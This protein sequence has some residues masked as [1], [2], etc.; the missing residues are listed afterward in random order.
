[1]TDPVE[2]SL[3]CLARHPDGSVEELPKERIDEI[4]KLTD[5]DGTLV[6]VSATAP[7]D[8][9]IAA[10]GREFRL[11]PLAL[12]DLHKQQQRPKLD[13]YERAAHGRRLRGGE[14]RARRA[15]SEIHMFVGAGWLLSVT[16]TATPMLDAVRDGFA[17]RRNGGPDTTGT[18]LYALLDAAV[19][20][21]FP[22]LDTISERI[23]ALEDRVLEG[24]ADRDSLAE[25]LHLKRRLLELRR[26]LAPMRDVANA[27]LRRDLEIVDASSAPYYQDLYDHLVRV[28]DQV[29]I[30]RDLLAAVLDARLTVASNSLNAIMKRLTAFTVVLM[31]PTLIA[32]IYGM[33]FDLM[34]EL[35]WPFGYP[36]AL[37]IMAPRWSSPS[38]TSAARAGSRAARGLH[39]SDGMTIQQPPDDEMPPPTPIDT[40]NETPNETP[41]P[42]PEQR[43]PGAGS[44]AD[45][46][47]ARRAR[48]R[49]GLTAAATGGGRRSVCRGLS[50]R[51]SPGNT[52]ITDGSWSL[53]WSKNSA[54]TWTTSYS[55]ALPG[56][57]CSPGS[58]RA[59]GCCRRTRSE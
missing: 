59:P 40:P 32:G 11:H 38:R 35:R 30:Y 58:G 6:W 16:W 12:E 44:A 36:L 50:P 39:R 33:N 31:V 54:L 26:V 43:A 15:V 8:E 24:E 56:A 9:D 20:S 1:M 51:S 55:G 19:D 53:A 25:I 18:L 45:G 23:D 27:L 7:S 5:R 4:D 41:D 46:R 42:M 49:D 21:Y 47:P 52:R 13:T 57:T 22:V 2:R 29:D 48:P 28:L 10:I 3:I 14:R 34:P 17:A 37:A